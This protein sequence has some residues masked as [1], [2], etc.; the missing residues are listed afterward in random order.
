[1]GNKI[2]EK[3]NIRNPFFIT[4]DG[5]GAP[6][7]PAAPE[8]PVDDP[9]VPVDYVEPAQV[10]QTV[11]C[12][13]EVNIGEDVGGKIYTLNVGKAT[14]NVTIDY[15]VNVPIS[16]TGY[17]DTSTPNFSST[18]YVGNDIFEQ[19]LLDAGIS[20]GSMNLG[21]GTQTGTVTINKTAETPETVNFLVSAP[22]RTDDYQLT[23][24]C[25][26]A[27]A[28]TAPAGN[29]PSTI[30]SHTGF[31]EQIP[32]FYVQM[33]DN[34]GG[35]NDF[36][37]LQLKVNGVVVVSEFTSTG[38]YVFSDYDGVQ[39]NFGVHQNVASFGG[40]HASSPARNQGYV[41]GLNG[42][43]SEWTTPTT[44]FAQSDYFTTDLNKIEFI[45]TLKD[46][47]SKW[48]QSSGS[49]NWAMK[50]DGSGPYVRFVKSG[51]FYDTV[52]SNWRYPINSQRDASRFDWKSSNNYPLTQQNND[53]VFI[54]NLEGAF[55]TTNP[56]QG[57]NEFSNYGDPNK[58]VMQF[59]WR[60]TPTAGL[61]NP[62]RNAGT[63]TIGSTTYA[64]SSSQ[65]AG[66]TYKILL[67][68]GAGG[69][70]A[71][72]ITDEMYA[73]DSGGVLGCFS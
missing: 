30:P 8:D 4:A 10:T 40:S 63:K 68:D 35:D 20:A 3:I 2:T 65:F 73:R 66:R 53:T 32:A 36:L 26:A 7:L 44:F 56:Y 43:I 45:Y 15:T 24:N 13:E 60:S 22:L 61:D 50:G 51:L 59:F 37:D 72:I 28:V 57:R 25:P 54:G 39:T 19:D 14:G 58:Y 52:N 11:Q 62:S 27:P 18:G 23:F 31:F 16:I 17:W 49:A 47:K 33:D 21:S 42:C 6:E 34:F 55:Q 71:S 1:M 48:P 29:V 9:D 70:D 12:G 67:D 41:Q 64:P 5:E 38:W 46:T 69:R